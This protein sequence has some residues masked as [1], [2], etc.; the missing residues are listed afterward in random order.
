MK[1]TVKPSDRLTAIAKRINAEHA[2][3][4]RDAK[5]AL[6]HHHA[7]GRELLKAK[8]RLEHGEFGPW[9]K[10]HVKV[11][12]RRANEYMQLATHW[13]DLKLADS[14]NLTD[15]L[16]RIALDAVRSREPEPEGQL[17][18]GPHFL[19][20]VM[21]TDDGQSHGPI[22]LVPELPAP[23]NSRLRHRLRQKLVAAGNREPTDSQ[24]FTSEELRA[25]QER[26]LQS[27]IKLVLADYQ[28]LLPQLC[29]AIRKAAGIEG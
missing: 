3:G 16:D 14:A 11:S 5:S 13:T 22:E 4:E 25:E 19:K 6:R 9:L 15:A 27:R 26:Q 21:P 17:Q 7:A 8:D 10:Q 12:W 2:A 23:N 20:V 1:E 18:D 28:N 29:E 24:V